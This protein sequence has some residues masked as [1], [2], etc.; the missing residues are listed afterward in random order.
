MCRRISKIKKSKRNRKLFILVI[1]LRIKKRIRRNFGYI[2]TKADDQN[3][4]YRRKLPL[5]VN[6]TI[7]SLIID[8]LFEYQYQGRQL[9]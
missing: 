3:I 1:P 9:G 2:T 5:L 7:A 4:L 6:Y 8:I